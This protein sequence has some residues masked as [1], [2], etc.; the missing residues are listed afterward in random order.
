MPS[1]NCTWPHFPVSYRRGISALSS[2]SAI[3]FRICAYRVQRRVPVRIR[4]PEQRRGAQL[5][6]NPRVESTHQRRSLP[7]RKMTRMSSAA[8][9]SLRTER[10]LRSVSL[11]LIAATCR[12]CASRTKR[13]R[14]CVL[15][16]FRFSSRLVLVP[17]LKMGDSVSLDAHAGSTDCLSLLDTLVNCLI[18]KTK[19][20][21]G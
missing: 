19:V 20:V 5:P 3:W 7:L 1:G 8:R 16:V 6:V 17:V 9:R 4:A 15:Q 21:Q 12:I 14:N 18:S 13:V 11:Y 10:W 2:F